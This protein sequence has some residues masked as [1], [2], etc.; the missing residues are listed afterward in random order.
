ILLYT[1]TFF[2]RYFHAVILDQDTNTIYRQTRRDK[3]AFGRFSDVM[4]FKQTDHK[5]RGRYRATTLNIVLKDQR[6]VRILTFKKSRVSVE[7]TAEMNRLLW[8]W[9]SGHREA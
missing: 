8:K 2:L 5:S 3:V 1:G 9:L 4:H 6:E 7:F